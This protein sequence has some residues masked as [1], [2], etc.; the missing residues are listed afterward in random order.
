MGN[1]A[2]LKKYPQPVTLGLHKEDFYLKTWSNRKSILEG[3]NLQGIHVIPR[4]KIMEGKSVV[5]STQLLLFMY[6][7]TH[8]QVTY[9]M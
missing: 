9:N 1:P 8:K 7:L 3:R 2:V 4:N 6:I 5:F